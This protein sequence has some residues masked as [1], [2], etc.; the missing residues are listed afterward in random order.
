M[1]VVKPANCGSRVKNRLAMVCDGLR[2]RSSTGESGDADSSLP[3]TQSVGELAL[4]AASLPVLPATLQRH[5]DVNERGVA[6]LPER[7]TLQE[8]S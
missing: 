7:L 1:D 8:V 3:M 5:S 6:P 4:H 2:V